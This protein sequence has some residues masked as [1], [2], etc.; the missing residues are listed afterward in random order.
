MEK[1]NFKKIIKILQKNT[2]YYLL[3]FKSANL[4]KPFNKTIN[5][6]KNVI[7]KI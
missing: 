7:K 4:K 6:N 3:S 1:K 5:Y 2:N